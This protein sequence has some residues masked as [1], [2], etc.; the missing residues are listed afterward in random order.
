MFRTIITAAALAAASLAFIPASHAENLIG[1]Q[2]VTA[3][4]VGGTESQSAETEA[5]DL[6]F[7]KTPI[8]AVASII[9]R[10]I[11]DVDHTVDPRVQGTLSFKSSRRLRKSELLCWFENA[12]HST[13]N[14]LIKDIQGYRLIPL[15]DNGGA[16]NLGASPCG[17]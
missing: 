6:Q 14:A 17:R 13:G 11:L 2:P 15:G 1:D 16:D 8:T 3:P 4:I 10:D 9:L 5:Y 7:D 12:A